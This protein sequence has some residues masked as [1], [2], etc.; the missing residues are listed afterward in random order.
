L[1]NGGTLGGRDRFVDCFDVGELV[2]T[3]DLRQETSA[4]NLLDVNV[5]LNDRGG[6]IGG[7]SVLQVVRLGN[8]TKDGTTDV[9]VGSRLI[10]SLGMREGSSLSDFSAKSGVSHCVKS[11]RVVVELT[12]ETLCG[13]GYGTHTNT[14]S[15]HTEP[16]INRFCEESN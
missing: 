13:R 10:D 16:Q 9:G 5:S 14:Q 2:L 4:V 8:L 3:L 7:L 1:A 12:N 15:G 11:R 6:L